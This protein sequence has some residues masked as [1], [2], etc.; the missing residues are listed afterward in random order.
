M[1]QV[2]ILRH[3]QKDG[4]AGDLTEEGREKARNIRSKLP[5]FS[6]V[7]ASGSHRTQ[8]TAKIL[9]SIDQKIDARAGYFQTSLEQNLIIDKMARQNPLG[10]TGA[11][12]DNEGIREN[13]K[14]KAKGLIELINETLNKLKDGQNALI[15]SHD[16]TMV[17][18]EQIMKHKEVGVNNKSFKYLSGFSVDEK[19]NLKPL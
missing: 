14:E 15:V 5:K 3:A 16:I 17:P 8:G 18:A 9:T 19:G 12:L 10:F 4:Q 6:L 11:Y 1:K 7:I 2:Y 13:V